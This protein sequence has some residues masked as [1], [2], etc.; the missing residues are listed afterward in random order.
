MLLKAE[1]TDLKLYL[2]AYSS[3][4]QMDDCDHDSTFVCNLLQ[5]GHN[6]AEFL[7][8]NCPP[9]VQIKMTLV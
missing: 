5:L 9:V 2:Q 4:Y 1:R 3:L 7:S 6:P 8:F